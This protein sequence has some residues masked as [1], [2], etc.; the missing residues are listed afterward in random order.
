MNYENT[1]IFISI[2]QMNKHLFHDIYVQTKQEACKDEHCGCSH[3]Y[4]C[5]IFFS[6]LKK[7]MVS[8][9]SRGKEF[10]RLITCCVRMYFLFIGFKCDAFNF[11]ECPLLRN[12]RKR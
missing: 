8:I 1:H 3:Q 2:K 6:E 11:I 9:M 4:I 7:L 5:V 12:R 10:H